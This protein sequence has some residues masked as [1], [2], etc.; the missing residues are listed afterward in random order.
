MGLPTIGG[1]KFQQ[2]IEEEHN[3]FREE[4]V[5]KLAIFERD[6]SCHVYPRI[7]VKPTINSIGYYALIDFRKMSNDE[8]NDLKTKINNNEEI[9]DKS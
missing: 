8:L 2:R 6:N 1:K 7:D 5:K 4:M 9:K 3:N